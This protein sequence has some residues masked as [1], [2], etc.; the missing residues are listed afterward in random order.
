MNVN[1]GTGASLFWRASG[2]TLTLLG[3]MLFAPTSSALETIKL[4]TGE[5][6]PPFSGSD[7]Q[8]GGVLTAL[9]V[10]TFTQRNLQTTVDFRPWSRGY[11]ESLKLSY[12]A[13]FPYIRTPERESE[14]L[15][16][17]PLYRLQSLLYVAPDSPWQEGSEQELSAVTFCLPTGY[18]TSGWIAEQEHRLKFVRPRTNLQCLEMLNRGRIDVIISNAANVKHLLV[19]QADSSLTL[20]QLPLAVADETLHLLVPARHPRAQELLSEFNLGLQQLHDNGAL[21]ALFASHPDYQ[22]NIGLAPP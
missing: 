7:L 16:S 13:T 18:E 10:R 5:D 3:A 14:F 1:V 12:D 2:C 22:A 9:V 15:F 19:Q 11:E 4:V 20:R 8:D 21:S 6:Y 17:A